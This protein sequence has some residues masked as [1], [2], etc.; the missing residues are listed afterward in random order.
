LGNVDYNNG[1]KEDSWREVGFASRHRAVTETHTPR[2]VGIKLSPHQQEVL[3]KSLAILKDHNSLLIKGKAGVGKTTLINFLAEHLLRSSPGVQDVLLLA[4]TNKAVSVLRKK[5]QSLAENF[6]GEKQISFTTLHSALG[7]TE[8]INE[9][10]GKREFKRPPTGEDQNTSVSFSKAQVVIIDEVSMVGSDLFNEI[11]KETHHLFSKIIVFTGDPGQI[12]PVGEHETPVFKYFDPFPDQVVELTEIVRQQQEN[13]IIN[14]SRN[15]EKVSPPVPHMLGNKGYTFSNDRGFLA[16]LL[17]NARDEQDEVKYIAFHNKKVERMN[18]MVRNRIYEK[19]NKVMQGETLIINIVPYKTKIKY[20]ASYELKVRELSVEEDWF[21]FYFGFSK[22]A[23]NMDEDADRKK[24]KPVLLKYYLINEDVKVVHE[25]SE[26][27]FGDM[28]EKIR[29]HIELD[30]KKMKEGHMRSEVF[31]K[32]GTHWCGY[33][34]FLLNFAQ[35]GYNH[36]ITV[37]KA[38]GSTYRTAIIDL[39]DMASLRD[40]KDFRDRLLYTAITRASEKVIF[41]I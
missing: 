22:K 34:H 8:H 3:E 10:T 13:P 20:Y 31:Y 27:D 6:R 33:Y 5:S 21:Y 26:K 7:L 37:H 14:L 23:E 2:P 28:L 39:W 24:S 12:P 40:S 38:Q 19:P 16:N 29:K 18:A 36:A 32:K 35:V 11:H 25:D 30:R 17:V 15:L 1:I 41:A 4:P 9:V